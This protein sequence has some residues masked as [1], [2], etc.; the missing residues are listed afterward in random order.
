[1]QR[2]AE[3]EAKRQGR[4]EERE[5]W[6]RRMAWCVFLSLFPLAKSVVDENKNRLDVG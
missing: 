3:R 4:K 5:R 2:S 6:S 1:V